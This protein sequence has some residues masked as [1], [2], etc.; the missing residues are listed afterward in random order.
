M[1]YERTVHKSS[2]VAFCD[3]HSVTLPIPLLIQ[4]ASGSIL[5]LSRFQPL[6]NSA[7]EE[8]GLNGGN[9]LLQEQLHAMSAYATA[10]SGHVADDGFIRRLCILL[11]CTIM[12]GDTIA[13]AWTPADTN[14]IALWYD[15][16][17]LS[18][19]HT[20]AS[21]TITRWDDR[22]GS[23]KHLTQVNG[24]P[25]P[26]RQIDDNTAIDFSGG[27]SIWTTNS[28]SLQGNP[29]LTIA[30][31]LIYD[32]MSGSRHAAFTL[33]SG[34]NAGAMF[35]AGTPSGYKMGCNSWWEQ[36]GP[37]SNATPLI[38]IGTRSSGGN[39]LASRMF[40][41]GTEHAPTASLQQSQ[42]PGINV[43]VTVGTYP[44][45]SLGNSNGALDGAVGEIIA[46]VDNSDDLREKLEGY[47]AHKWGLE[48]NLP[49]DHPYRGR[50]PGVPAGTLI[51][52]Y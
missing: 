3:R 29:N 47:L 23:D 15:A 36:Y 14:T 50:A 39:Y 13:E 19:I 30:C 12:A 48:A 28:H 10:R 20:N 8:D 5:P 44:T 34:W 7:L 37:V 22:S 4:F 49:K 41:N 27:S 26:T 43:G 24:T 25:G 40:I 33:G 18:T 1:R 17:D 6:L 31:V 42:N 51:S 11:M 46:Y 45:P 9:I 21:N 2:Q 32:T 52:V 38:Q 35:I 16:S